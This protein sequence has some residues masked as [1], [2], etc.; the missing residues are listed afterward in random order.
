MTMK[1]VLN[2]SRT[3]CSSRATQEIPVYV[4]NKGLPSFVGSTEIKRLRKVVDEKNVLIE[5]F[6]K[7]DEE[8]KEYYKDIQGL[9]DHLESEN[10]NLKEEVNQLQ[11]DVEKLRRKQEPLFA[12]ELRLLME[13]GDINATEYEKFMTLYSYWLSHRN[14]VKLYKN[15]LNTV[16]GCIKNLKGDL[17]SIKDTLTTAGNMELLDRLSELMYFMTSHLDILQQRL[18]SSID[19]I[20]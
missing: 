12:P 15:R 20:E 17:Q 7:Y 3:R 19:K 14:D 2:N 13:S 16:R 10:S 1:E 5:N 6:K 8:R 11:K 18:S 4:P 9:V